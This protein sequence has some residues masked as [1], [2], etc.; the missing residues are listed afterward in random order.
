MGHKAVKEIIKLIDNFLGNGF[1][2][3]PGGWGRPPKLS[4]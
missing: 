4:P 2:F 3:L 1:A